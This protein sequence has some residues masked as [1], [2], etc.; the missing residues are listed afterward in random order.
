MKNMRLEDDQSVSVF[1]R[2]IGRKLMHIDLV[3]LLFA[4]AIHRGIFEE[5]ALDFFMRDPATLPPLPHVL[6]VKDEHRD[7]AVFLN[8]RQDKAWTLHGA[9]KL[10]KKVSRA[11]KW[12]RKS[13]LI[14]SFQYSSSPDFTLYSFRIGFAGAFANVIPKASR[15]Q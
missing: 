3:L 1:L 4:V 2:T 11:L 10:F 6:R 8:D 5:D 12:T 15:V 9:Q 7:S 14:D 13:C